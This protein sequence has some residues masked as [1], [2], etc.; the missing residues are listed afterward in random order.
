MQKRADAWRA[1]NHRIGLVPTM[2]ALHDGHLSLVRRARALSDRTVVSIFVN[3]S[4]FDPNE[5]FT[6]YPRPLE[7]DIKLCEDEGVDIVFLP[8]V[9]EMYPQNFQTDVNVEKLTQGLC[10]ASRPN[11]FKGV[12]TVVAK[13]FNIV[14]PHVAV[15]G[16][17]D[18]QQARVVER[19]TQD[20]NFDLE[21]EVVPIVRDGTGL[22]VSSRN[23]YLSVQ[24]KADATILFQALLLG[25]SLIRGG[26]RRADLIKTAMGELINAI[27]SSRID[28][29]EIVD[30]KNL[31]PVE[32]I[33]NSVLLALAVFN[34]PTRLIDNKV[35]TV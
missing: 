31:Q 24:Q 17:K 29:L 25:E 35:V 12:T 28:Y 19:M 33:K 27:E 2:G 10:G 13:L 22:A 15:F 6:Q 8:T 3:P 5:D 14:K 34:G 4:Q 11:H 32:E 26:E 21:I 18:F 30:L 20:L 23:Q 9:D 7:K 16:A 1:E